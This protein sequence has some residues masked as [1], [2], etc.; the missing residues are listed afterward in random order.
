MNNKEILA[1]NLIKY[2][3]LRN[4]SRK[5]V[6]NDIGVSYYT[7]S[8]WVNGKKYPRMD[9][10][11][12]LAEYFGI[13]KSDLIEDS[14]SDE[15]N[16]YS[17]MDISDEMKKLLNKLQATEHKMTVDGKPLDENTRELLISSLEN[18]LKIAK[19]MNFRKE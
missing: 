14:S 2:M 11:E 15:M 3:Q 9:K 18:S 13:T 17:N 12:L 8:D 1:S 19:M 10:I 7:F 4:K 16:T 6:S 5:E